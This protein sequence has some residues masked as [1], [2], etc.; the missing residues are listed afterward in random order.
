MDSYFALYH[1]AVQQYLNGRYYRK[2]PR[3]QELFAAMAQ[4]RT[5]CSDLVKAL[6]T[7]FGY[8]LARYFLKRRIAVGFRPLMFQGGCSA[9]V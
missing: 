4:H 6:N 1:Y 7:P 8:N 5:W 2:T 3:E 9:N